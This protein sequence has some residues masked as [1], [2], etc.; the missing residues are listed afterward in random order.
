MIRPTHCGALQAVLWRYFY[1][2][3]VGQF[4]FLGILH[5]RSGRHVVNVVHR[6][7]ASDHTRYKR[8]CFTSTKD[9]IHASSRLRI[10]TCIEYRL[11]AIS[12]N[13][14]LHVLGLDCKCSEEV[15]YRTFVGLTGTLPM[16]TAVQDISPV[17]SWLSSICY[18]SC[19]AKGFS[20]LLGTPIV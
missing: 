5:F 20:A 19:E 16:F 10:G 12:W 7:S 14:L 17:L 3:P 2:K 6:G 18:L 1:D 15:G 4:S 11:L 13:L 8:A 9:W